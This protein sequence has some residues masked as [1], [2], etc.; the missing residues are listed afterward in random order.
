MADL[1]L[2]FPKK[3]NW[4]GF[5]GLGGDGGQGSCPKQR[6]QHHLLAGTE[7]TLGEGKAGVLGLGL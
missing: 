7:A 1:A 4:A 5:G 3:W 2:E 6:G